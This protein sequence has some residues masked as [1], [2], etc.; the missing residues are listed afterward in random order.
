MAGYRV[1]LYTAA[2]GFGKSAYIKGYLSTDKRTLTHID[3]AVIYC[4]V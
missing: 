1:T 4:F 3:S 2:K